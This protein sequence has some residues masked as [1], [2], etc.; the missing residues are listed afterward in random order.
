M[1][2]RNTFSFLDHSDETSTVSWE[3]VTLTAANFDAQATEFNS[4]NSALLNLTLGVES[5]H[6]RGL[7]T[8]GTTTPPSDPYAQRELKWL[9][10]Y[11]DATTG[12][13]Y[14]SEIPTPDL[15]DNLIP[16]TDQA[17]VTSA[18]WTAFVT[19]FE[20]FVTAPDTG[21]AVEF[22]SARLVG[23]NI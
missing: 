2:T 9:V 21:N 19:A 1:P 6:V 14:Q 17:D 15:T 12:K 7:V 23:R 8:E 4:L 20:A 16:G 11:A 3:S 18:D 13:R 5:Q 10:T 22:V